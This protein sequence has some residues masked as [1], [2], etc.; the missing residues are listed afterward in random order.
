MVERG[1]RVRA[2]VI[3]S[4][5]GEPLSGAVRANANAVI[6]KIK[7]AARKRAKADEAKRE[8]TEDLRGYIRD[9]REA[10]VSIT[11]IASEA[12]LSR[13]GVYD[14]LG[15]RPSAQRRRSRLW[16]GPE[17]RAPCP[18]SASWPPPKANQWLRRV[19]F[20]AMQVAA[21]QPSRP[22]AGIGKSA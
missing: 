2:R 6:R 18:S 5:R 10:G 14:L 22:L 21:V 7:A 3:A 1:G 4:R 15:E 13:Q 20:W 8:A 12:G 19:G 9:A 11:R 16:S 17:S